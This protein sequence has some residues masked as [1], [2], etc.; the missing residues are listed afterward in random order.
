MMKKS[1]L[2]IILGIF[3]GLFA[4]CGAG[5]GGGS[6]A[7][8]GSSFAVDLQ[9]EKWEL[10]NLPQ[11]F[12]TNTA[13]FVI[14]VLNSAGIEEAR[15][16]ILYPRTTYTFTGLTAGSK[17]VKVAACDING[18]LLAYGQG[19]VDLAESSASS[20][21]V[22]TAS[23][24]VY[25]GPP[26]WAV[27]I[28]QN[29]YDQTWENQ[30]TVTY[31]QAMMTAPTAETARPN[32]YLVAFPDGQTLPLENQGPGGEEAALSYS[33]GPVTDYH[34][35]GYALLYG[36][37]TGIYRQIMTSLPAGQLAGDYCFDLA[38]ETQQISYPYTYPDIPLISAPEPYS[39][40]DFSSSFLVRWQDLGENYVYN[41][42]LSH[43]NGG[44]KD[45][46]WSYADMRGFN[47]NNWQYLNVF[48]NRFTNR[49]YCLIPGGILPAD[50]TNVEL[51]VRAFRTDWV[52]MQ[53]VGDAA[54]PFLTVGKVVVP[55]AAHKIMLNYIGGQQTPY[56]SSLT[57][58]TG[59][60]GSTVTLLG[61]RFGSAQG[62]NRVLFNETDAGS[63]ATW[64]D[65]MITVQV[66]SGLASNCQ[67][68]VQ[69]NGNTSNY[70][71]FYVTY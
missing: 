32:S 55:N 70:Q 48:L 27:V 46:F 68:T 26:C 23:I 17:T 44:I 54:N 6:A 22:T 28:P 60:V 33:Y 65:T 62:E 8:T 64:S 63:A 57:P 53:Y 71:N 9:P 58:T 10:D 2:I 61:G 42:E 47:P 50:T 40:V 39:R 14:Q 12:P 24:T 36:R 69:V 41:V 7:Q 49:N 19:S 38:G 34:N 45:Y 31:C 37:G 29:E 43:D 66:P 30:N 67:V 15:T 1:V 4:G 20:G 52:Q 56:L 13:C 18:Q 51:S 59:P 35:V 25:P 16:T 11:G 3:L 5:G 21:L